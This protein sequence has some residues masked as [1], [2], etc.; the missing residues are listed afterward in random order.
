M[1]PCEEVQNSHDEKREGIMY[2][3]LI[4]YKLPQGKPPSC[5]Y[6]GCSNRLIPCKPNNEANQIKI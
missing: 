2:C 1:A 3:F 4:V 5:G 6:R